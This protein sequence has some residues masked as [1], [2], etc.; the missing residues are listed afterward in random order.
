MGLRET[1]DVQ[2]T[3]LY[4]T[5]HLVDQTVSLPSPSLQTFPSDGESFTYYPADVYNNGNVILD[6]CG[7]TQ[8]IR[9]LLRGVVLM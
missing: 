8:T 3:H 9:W 4:H 1:A 2:T 7:E 6:S 5:Q